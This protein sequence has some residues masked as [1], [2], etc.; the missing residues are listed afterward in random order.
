[1]VGFPVLNC[2]K[3]L[4]GVTVRTYTSLGSSPVNEDCAKLG[5]ANYSDLAHIEIEVFRRQIIRQ[6][7]ELPF[8][9]ALKERSFSHDYGTYYELCF[10]YDEDSD[11]AYNYVSL[12]EDFLPEYWDS[13][14]KEDLKKAGYYLVKER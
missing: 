2:R 6:F 9:V 11:D 5:S 14:S 1:M 3:K 4:K 10:F 7:G 13:L 12:C 8:G